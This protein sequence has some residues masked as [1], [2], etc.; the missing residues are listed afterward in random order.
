MLQNN[1][2]GQSV[3]VVPRAHS[4]EYLACLLGVSSGSYL[5]SNMGVFIMPVKSWVVAAV[6]VMCDDLVVFQVPIDDARHPQATTII[7]QFPSYHRRRRTAHDLR[8]IISKVYIA[9]RRQP[10]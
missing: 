5:T 7:V 2:H 3:F 1:G 4:S 8:A 9:T 10:W 6:L